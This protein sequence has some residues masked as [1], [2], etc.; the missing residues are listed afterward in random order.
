MVSKISKEKDFFKK[1]FS[2]NVWFEFLRTLVALAGAVLLAAI[3]I[4]ITSASPIESV[5][6]F[7]LAPLEGS[8]SIGKVFTE[9][10][11]LIFTGVAVCLMIQ[12]GQFNM[13]VEGAFFAGGLIAAV[14]AVKLP[15]PVVL[16]PWLSMLVAGAITGVVGYIPAKLKASLGVNEF[17]TSLMFNFIVFWICMYLF[18]YWFADPDYSSLA[19]PML[20]DEAKLPYLNYDNEVSSNILIAMVVVIIS[21]FFLFRTKWGYAIRMTGGNQKFAA[22]SGIKTKAVIVYSQ[23]IGAV[24]AGFGGAA[25]ILGNFY[26]FNWK[27]LP[28]YGFDGFVVA[29]IARNNPI[30]VPFAAIFIGYLRTGAMEMARLSDVPNEVVY[31]IQ[32]LMMILVG[33]QSFLASWKKRKIQLESERMKNNG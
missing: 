11:P 18:T 8:Y 26:R 13:F 5:R 28:N 33:A 24:I 31:I 10:V 20:S 6:V 30:L 32:A 9:A 27:A 21:A 4:S 15:V 16:L 14:S 19:T 3:I 22:Y 1:F 12:C 2:F 23:V 7:F 29:I 25:F 17:V